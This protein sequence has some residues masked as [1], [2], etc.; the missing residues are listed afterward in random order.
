MNLF[1]IQINGQLRPIF[2]IAM[3]PLISKLAVYQDS[4]FFI[5]IDGSLLL[6]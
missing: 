5:L 3:N 6:I 4:L 1:D 2:I